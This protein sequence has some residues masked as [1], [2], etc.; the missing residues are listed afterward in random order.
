MRNDEK[1]GIFKGP[2]IL[3]G[4]PELAFFLHT[5]TLHLL[6]E[7]L[8]IRFIKTPQ[9]CFLH[10]RLWHFLCTT[11]VLTKSLDFHQYMLAALCSR[12][13]KA[14]GSDLGCLASNSKQKQN[15]KQWQDIDNDSKF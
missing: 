10:G 15:R 5:R 9:I 4:R 8:A 1:H 3:L 6:Q 2:R 12:P 11:L 13:G 7:A 14:S